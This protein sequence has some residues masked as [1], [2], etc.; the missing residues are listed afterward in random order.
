M[1]VPAQGDDRRVLEQAQRVAARTG[2]DAI[3]NLLLKM[4]G[5]LVSNPP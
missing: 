5:G 2:E 3:A 4:Q 1:R